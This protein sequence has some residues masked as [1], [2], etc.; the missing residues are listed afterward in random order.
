MNSQIPPPSRH[1]TGSHFLL[2]FEGRHGQMFLLDQ[3]NVGGDDR[4]H[5]QSEALETCA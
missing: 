4:C 1:R 3:W 5:C 2:A